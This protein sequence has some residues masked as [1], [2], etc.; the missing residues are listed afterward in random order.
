[1]TWQSP[2]PTSTEELVPE[3]EPSVTSTTERPVEPI[4]PTSPEE[5]IDE[6]KEPKSTPETQ[7]EVPSKPAIPTLQPQQPTKP[8]PPAVKEPVKQSETPKET[9][10]TTVDALKNRRLEDD[11]KLLPKEKQDFLTHL[12][13]TT[14]RIEPKELMLRYDAKATEYLQ[15]GHPTHWLAVFADD[16]KTR[17]APF[18]QMIDEYFYHMWGVDADGEVTEYAVGRDSTEPVINACYELPDLGQVVRCTARSGGVKKLETI[19]TESLI[20]LNKGIK[21]VSCSQHMP[22]AAEVWYHSIERMSSLYRQL[23]D[24]FY[25]SEDNKRIQLENHSK[26]ACVS[27]IITSSRLGVDDT[28][29]AKKIFYISVD[30]QTLKDKYRRAFSV[31]LL[32]NAGKSPFIFEDE[33]KEGRFMT[34]WGFCKW[35][36]PVK[37]VWVGNVKIIPEFISIK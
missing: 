19:M 35:T 31:E 25:M 15:T 33:L 34:V 29:A 21:E 9:Q 36:P 27:G 13:K 26:F 14:Y 18:M 6:T 7:P 24:G 11:F 4:P 32:F 23:E 5:I 20:R 10:K 8:T 2:Q 22:S 28:K 3:L 17:N 1:M 37:E 30:D 12:A 16:A